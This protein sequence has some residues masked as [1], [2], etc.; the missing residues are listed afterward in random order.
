MF[1]RS[2]A[3]AMRLELGRRIIGSASLMLALCLG[4]VSG[5]QTGTPSANATPFPVEETNIAQLHAAYLTGKTTAHKITQ[6]Y[7]DRIT[8]YDKRGPYFNSIITVNDHALA[9]AD[10]LDVAL[11][12]TGKLTGPLHGIPVVVKDNLDTFDLPTTSGVLLFKEFVPPKDAFV[13]ERVRR[14]GGIVLA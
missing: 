8:A 13:V 10:R 6:A 1:T 5:R 14:A 4:T 9:D 7:I 3:R 12:V 11:K 2:G